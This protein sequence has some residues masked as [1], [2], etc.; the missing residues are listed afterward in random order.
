MPVEPLSESERAKL[1]RFPEEIP[2]EDLQRHFTLLDEDLRV[3]EKRRL[4]SNRL[5]FS[6]LS[7]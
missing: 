5:G 6:R 4:D 3:V 7:V 1:S 2:P